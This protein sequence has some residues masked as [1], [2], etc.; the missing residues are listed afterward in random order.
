MNSINV[1]PI[2]L[3][4]FIKN[5]SCEGL[6]SP[7]EQP[8]PDNSIDALI[9]DPPY[10]INFQNHEWDNDKNGKIEVPD[11]KIWKDCF[12]VMK[13]G[14]YGLVFS[15]P[16]VMHR[17]MYHLEEA[18]FELKDVLFWVYLNGM[19]KT[20]NI[21]LE[22]DKEL[23]VESTPTKPYKYK[24]GYEKN[25]A[26][27]YKLGEQKFRL[28]PNSELGR[29]FNGAGVNIKPSYEPIILVKKPIQ[30]GLTIAQNII[31]YG[32]G[33]LNL[34]DTRIPYEKNE[35][36]V[37]HNPH[38]KGRVPANLVRIEHISKED[39]FKDGHNKYFLPTNPHLPPDNIETEF[40]NQYWD[41]A[42]FVS[43][44]RQHAEDFNEHPTLKPIQLMSHLVKLVSFEN[45]LILDPFM[46]SGSTGIAAIQENRKFIGYEID[47][48]YFKISKKRIEMIQQSM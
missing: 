15:F 29:K 43:K 16:R 23:G 47:E 21:G 32:V 22:I 18:G 19:P 45:Q 4:T 9:T 27:T 20:R 41:R 31:K 7:N 5:S 35:G 12:R 6:V 37:G 46:G 34:E 39:I 33:A 28:E 24:Q 36:K 26:E 1:N 40:F 11:R 8:L 25:G 44:V 13:P 2:S 42:V 3:K 38:P 48:N 30:E 17:V 10:G 14:A